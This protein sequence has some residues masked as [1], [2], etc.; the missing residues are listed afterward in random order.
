M[1]MLR[2]LKNFW[3]HPQLSNLEYKEFLRIILPDLYNHSL[4]SE[5]IYYSYQHDLSSLSSDQ[6]NKLFRGNRRPERGR[7]YY[8]AATFTKELKNWLLSEQ[9]IIYTRRGM[10]EKTAKESMVKNI[11]K[12]VRTDSVPMTRNHTLFLNLECSKENLYDLELIQMM[13]C[14]LECGTED[15]LVYAL[16][17]LILVAIFQDHIEE[18]KILYSDKEIS[19]VVEERFLRHGSEGA[20]LLCL[21]TANYKYLTD[22]A[23]MN[24]YYVYTYETRKN[25]VCQCGCLNIWME[26]ESAMATL[27]L[28]GKEGVVSE[29]FDGWNQA[30]VGSPIL[31]LK[32]NVVMIVF[33]KKEGGMSILCFPYESEHFENIESCCGFLISNHARMEMPQ[34]QKMIISKRELEESSQSYV[35]GIMKLNQ[36]KVLITERQLEKFLEEFAGESWMEEFKRGILP[37]IQGH[38]VKGYYFSEN[39]ILSY[40]LTDMDEMDRLKVVEALK[41]RSEAEEFI[42]LQSSEQLEKVMD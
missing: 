24:E 25:K 23:Y 11:Q 3:N 35:K 10:E 7:R 41:S 18:L 15:A 20:V 36:G 6:L 37:F 40:T 26:K 4:T 42:T 21:D 38:Y 29:R 34:V 8:A 12:Y 22:D 27:K 1:I 33:T 16:F 2:D 28:S 14:L 30:M 39:E 9:K 5:E 31:N 17:L 32:D 19:K 13:K